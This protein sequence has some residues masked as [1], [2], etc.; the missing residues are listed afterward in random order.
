MKII[1]RLVLAIALL[2]AG[3]AAGFPIGKS[4]GF[5]TGSEWALLQADIIARESGLFMPVSLEEGRF[6]III[7]QP[8]NLYK[9]AWQL[10]DKREKETPNLNVEERTLN[11]TVQLARNTSLSQLTQ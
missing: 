8:R 2:A 10:A 6:R 9:R 3:F 1:I 11:E 4:S 7:R 5:A